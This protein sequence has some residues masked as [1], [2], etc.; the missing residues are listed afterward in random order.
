CRIIVRSEIIDEGDYPAVAAQSWDNPL[1]APAWRFPV[2]TE[3]E[4]ELPDS[5]KGRITDEQ[6][7]VTIGKNL[8]QGF[9]LYVSPRTDEDRTLRAP[10]V[11][12]RKGI[13][14]FIMPPEG[15]AKLKPWERKRETKGWTD[16]D[17][18]AS[19]TDKKNP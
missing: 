8:P 12:D 16:L 5:A 18:K 19:S 4:V 13:H 2:N 1:G 6:I 7:L 14:Y 10:Y 17:G 11:V 15:V 3:I 9:S